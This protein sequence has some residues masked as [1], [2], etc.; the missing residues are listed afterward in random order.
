MDTSS[1]RPDCRLTGLSPPPRQP[2]SL[3]N[4]IQVPGKVSVAPV[5]CRFPPAALNLCLWTLPPV[6]AV[7][8]CLYQRRPEG[9]RVGQAECRLFLHLAG[10]QVWLMASPGLFEGVPGVMSIFFLRVGLEQ[11]ESNEL[12]LWY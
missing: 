5:R 12:S 1:P 9:S 6:S 7:S 3:R 2:A 4:G 10:C 11:P 8:G